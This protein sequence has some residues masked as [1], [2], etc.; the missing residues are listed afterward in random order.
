MTS[1]I[2]TACGQSVRRKP[3]IIYED[4]TA[5]I[6]QITRGYI[7]GDRTKHLAPKLFFAHELNTR[8]IEVKYVQSSGNL[9]DIFTK[10]LPAS[11]HWQIV[12]KLGMR[13][14]SEID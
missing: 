14:L 7:K 2:L 6:A 9:A 13:R 1:T 12:P 11:T 5:C 4:N 8:Q 10:S 3:T